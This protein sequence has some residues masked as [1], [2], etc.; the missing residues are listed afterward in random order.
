M[1]LDDFATDDSE[2]KT[3]P[4]HSPERRFGRLLRE[5]F[6]DRGYEVHEDNTQ[7]SSGTDLVVEKDRILAMEIKAHYNEDPKQQVYTALGQVLYGMP[8]EDIDNDDGNWGIAFPRRIKNETPYVDRVEEMLSRKVLAEL[9]IAV[10]FA[11]A[12]GMDIYLPGE[13]GADD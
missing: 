7:G 12:N 4:Y 1:G 6:K 8:Y 3:S 5:K 9:S 2:K 11:D 10:V 13:I